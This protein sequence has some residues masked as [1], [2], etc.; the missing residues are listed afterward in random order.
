M[1]Q[2]SVHGKRY[3]APPVPLRKPEA[4]LLAKGTYLNIELLANPDEEHSPKYKKDV[5]F[6]SDGTPEEYLAWVE[7]LDSVITGTNVEE[8]RN[9]YSMARRLLKGNALTEFNAL[10]NSV[11]DADGAE[12]EENYKSILEE[13]KASVFPKRALRN[14]LRYFRRHMRKPAEMPVRQYFARAE[15]IYGYMAKFPNDNNMNKVLSEEERLDIYECH[16]PNRWQNAMYAQGFDPLENSL[17][18]LIEQAER[19]ETID[20]RSGTKPSAGPKERSEGKRTPHKKKQ[21]H[22]HERPNKETAKKQK[23]CLIHGDCYHST[24][25]CKTMQQQASNMKATYNAQGDRG[26]KARFRKAQEANQTESV[27]QVLKSLMKKPARKRKVTIQED[28]D[29]NE[30]NNLEDFINENFNLGDSDDEEHGE[31]DA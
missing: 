2:A 29:D 3:I 6:F 9:K 31:H 19:Q 22:K 28:E 17:T 20:A 27:K 26:G 18:D 25:E 1:V 10:A 30:V 12:N 13:L 7:N 5:P 16:L 24:D 23:F 21:H 11:G 14:Q 15:E 4:K 8:P